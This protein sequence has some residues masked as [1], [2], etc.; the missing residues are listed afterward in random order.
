MPPAVAPTPLAKTTTP[1][2]TPS[3][4]GASPAVNPT[5]SD[6]SQIH[7]V[8]TG[9]G[10]VGK[11]FAAWCLVQYLRDKGVKVE[12]IDTDPI[13]MSLCGFAALNARFVPLL[14]P[15][16]VS[17][18]TKEINRLSQLV[19]TTDSSYVIDN[20]A[21]SF[22]PYGAYLAGTEFADVAHQ[23]DRELVIHAIIA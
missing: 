1:A 19:L 22:L 16:N 15:D 21:A 6:R 9:K 13:N 23:Q 3:D 12:A 20:G 5:A 8:L 14:Q 4:S 17:L 18:N 11:T 10:G 7:C 2:S